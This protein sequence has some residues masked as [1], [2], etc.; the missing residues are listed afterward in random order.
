M[1]RIARKAS[2]SR[3]IHGV[4]VAAG[5]SVG[6]P[7]FPMMRDEHLFPNP[8]TFDPER[9]LADF[10]YNLLDLLG[11]LRQVIGTW[12]CGSIW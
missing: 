1:N 9:Y 7:V 12:E 6:L 2:E 4:T 8:D 3:T 10:T 5:A 11:H